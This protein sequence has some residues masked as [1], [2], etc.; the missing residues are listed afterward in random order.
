MSVKR[1]VQVHEAH[2]IADVA[3]VEAEDFESP[4]SDGYCD[5][6]QRLCNAGLADHE[7]P[8]SAF[9]SN[10]VGIVKI[11]GLSLEPAAISSRG[12]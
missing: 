9:L 3:S 1:D 7:I 10:G 11:V 2:R 5:S 8:V 4:I 12:C 6:S